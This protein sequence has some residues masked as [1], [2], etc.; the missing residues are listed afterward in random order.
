MYKIGEFSKI[1]ELSVKTLRYY[2]EENILNP[3]YRNQENGYR[4]YSEEDYDKAMLI[5]LLRKLNF[6]IMELKDVLKIYQSKS[7]LPYILE[8]KKAIIQKK[9]D[10]EKAL[11]KEIDLFIHSNSKEKNL[12]NYQVDIRIVAP[13]LVA[14][15]R[16]HGKY[17][18]LGK[19]IAE[20]Y[21]NLK[22]NGCGTPFNCYYEEGYKEIV[23]IEV[24]VP[25]KKKIDNS[26]IET[27]ELPEIKAIHTVHYGPYDE[28][29]KAYK[30]IIDYAKL[31]NLKCVLPSREIYVKGPGM[32]FKGN[33]NNYIT[34][35]LVPFEDEAE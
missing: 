34:E 6:S 23:D 8:E 3:S 14:S 20:I 30:T 4:Y 12:M 18:E 7:D 17:S 32:I 24:C 19:Y 13:V 15:I 21:K 26:N 9:I 1:T 25:T 11:L 16:Y 22:G 33:P 28:I 31:N 35:I 10:K 5:V 27:K 2:D 29:G